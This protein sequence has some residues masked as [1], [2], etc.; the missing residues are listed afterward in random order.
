MPANIVQRAVVVAYQQRYADDMIAGASKLICTREQLPAAHEH[1]G[2]VAFE[3]VGTGVEMFGQGGSACQELCSK[4]GVSG[5]ISAAG[6]RGS[7]A[8]R[9][10][11]IVTLAERADRFN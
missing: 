11:W 1:R 6:C 8:L 4:L 2:P 3:A 10:H 7:G 9:S 5:T